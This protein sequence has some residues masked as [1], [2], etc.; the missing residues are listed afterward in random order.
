MLASWPNTKSPP[1]RGHLNVSALAAAPSPSNRT[2]A[3]NSRFIQS[4]PQVSWFTYDGEMPA[5]LMPRPVPGRRDATGM[6]DHAWGGRR[7]GGEACGTLTA[8]P[9]TVKRLTETNAAAH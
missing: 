5:C 6:L 8:G 9:S 2:D 7:R 3:R 4:G 1:V